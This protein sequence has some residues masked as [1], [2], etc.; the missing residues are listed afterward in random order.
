MASSNTTPENG[1]SDSET[2]ES[3]E[4]WRA[5]VERYLPWGDAPV[6]TGAVRQRTTRTVLGLFLSPLL[7]LPSNGTAVFSALLDVIF[8][9][10]L[11]L[12]VVDGIVNAIETINDLFFEGIFDFIGEFLLGFTEFF[13][14]FKPPGA[15]PSLVALY[16]HTS[17]V[18]WAL[19]PL[20]CAIFFLGYQ[21]FPE[22]QSAD[23]YQ[24]GQRAL[25]AVVMLIAGKPLVH[26]AVLL[27][28]DVGRF[29]YPNEYSLSLLNGGLI[30]GFATQ[31]VALGTGLG[32]AFLHIT[33]GVAIGVPLAS[34]LIVFYG[35][36][37]MRMILVYAFYG[38]FPLLAVMWVFDIG[39][40]K[41]G[42]MVAGLMFKVTAII[43]FMGI[44]V[45]GILA[46]SGAIA[47]SQGDYEANTYQEIDVTE[48]PRGGQTASFERPQEGVTR[49]GEFDS[50]SSGGIGHAMLGIFSWFGGLAL[51][52][53]VVTLLPISGAITQFKGRGGGRA[54]AAGSEQSGE[55][56][57]DDLGSGYGDGGLLSKSVDK[58]DEATG[59]T[60]SDWAS[61]S[62]KD[63]LFGDD[64]GMFDET[65]EDPEAADMGPI[66][67]DELGVG[68]GDDLAVEGGGFEFGAET[69]NG[70][71]TPSLGARAAGAVKTGAHTGTAA[72]GSVANAART[73]KAAGE[74]AYGAYEDIY[75]A[76]S[77]EDA[78]DASFDAAGG[79]KDSAFGGIGKVKENGLK[80][81]LGDATDNLFSAPTSSP[82]VESLEHKE[83]FSDAEDLSEAAT[84]I[85]N[86]NVAAQEELVEKYDDL[87]DVQELQSAV[88]R[89]S[90]LSTPGQT[91]GVM[92][93]DYSAG[94]AANGDGGGPAV[95]E[96]EMGDLVERGALAP[97][98]FTHGDTQFSEDEFVESEFDLE[99]V[100]FERASEET[101]GSKMQ[102]KGYFVD[103]DSGTR[104]PY[105]N[106]NENAPSL[107]DGEVYDVSG[108]AG[109]TFTR[110]NGAN[111]PGHR[112]VDHIKGGGQYRQAK[113]TPTMTVSSPGSGGGGNPGSTK[114]VDET[115][116]DMPDFSGGEP[117]SGR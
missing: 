13:L 4:R 46:A 1:T 11:Q 17:V 104:I 84:A 82:D 32:A 105:V 89:A 58:L 30:D 41:Y 52:V 16:D 14:F 69:A 53:F 94:A 108:V 29:I 67:D 36:L 20:G 12:N 64:E 114:G 24:L 48:P 47:N 23:P 33:A 77:W 70:T 10:P 112:Q 99:G 116:D 79:A 93:W 63:A 31:M 117:D 27:T 55:A 68:D 86:S 113:G 66:T 61:D 34:L 37:A 9:T 65:F 96:E 75:G 39:P 54:M 91:D 87:S 44:L 50:Q 40:A 8:L 97:D 6:A 98:E 35:T 80:Q 59:G 5:I 60:L 45:S 83:I 42:K 111:H 109:S 95:T 115:T 74:S 51:A 57:D 26:Y 90:S 100:R 71:G 15:Y 19:L 88:D 72:A 22:S 81:S 49:G 21:M 103:Q 43:L 18:F 85:E 3:T 110:P 25:A 76:D 73:G 107:N 56:L 38:L 62:P 92:D 106:F 102:E 28:N 2:L 78:V 101:W 7:S